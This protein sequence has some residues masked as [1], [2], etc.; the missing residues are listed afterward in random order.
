[1]LVSILSMALAA[2]APE[3]P[4]DAPKG[5]APKVMVLNVDK[6]GRGYLDAVVTHYQTVTEEV[7]MVV[8]GQVQKQLRPVSVP[9]ME[10]RRVPLDG[11][12]V[13][14]YGS[15]G[16]KI[17]PKNLP[18]L[19]AAVPVLVSA[20]GKEVDPFYL[21]LAKQGT[22]IVVSQSLA[23]PG[24]LEIIPPARVGDPVPLPVPPPLPP[25]P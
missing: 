2:P 19:T 20:N 22:L 17:D 25:K 14:V 10:Q 1:M 8:N 4:P 16:K 5:P 23:G 21:G 3:P 7:T 6:D 9:V 12:G 11:D 24:A 15:D 13:T 18:K